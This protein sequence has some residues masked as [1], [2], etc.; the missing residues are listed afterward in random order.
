MLAALG[1]CQAERGGPA[2]EDLVDLIANHCTTV[3]TCRCEGDLVATRCDEDLTDRWNT[4]IRAGEERELQYDA[5]CFDQLTADVDRY[6]CAYSGGESPLCGRFCAVYHG[7]KQ[8]GSSCEGVDSLVSDCAQGLVCSE[9]TCVDPCAVLGGRLLDEPCRDPSGGSVYDDCAAGLFCDRDLFPCQP[10]AELGQPCRSTNGACA[11]GLSCNWDSDVCVTAAAA[12]ESC[13]NV[14]C[15]QGLDCDWINDSR[16]C[17]VEA[18]E[19]EDC[20]QAR[21]AGDLYCNDFNFCQDAPGLDELCL[22]GNICAF[23]L[24]CDVPINRCVALPEADQPCL[25]NR[26]AAGSWCLSSADDP[27]GTCIAPA[28]NGEMCS[29]HS[30]C[31]SG[32]CPNGFCW[33]RSGAGESCAEGELCAPGL[34]CNGQTCEGSLTRAPAVCSYPGW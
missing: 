14:E 17:V 16:I 22:F 21:C 10:L 11:D 3:E 9:G 34:V 15:A 30:Q 29:G 8:L 13:D 24:A 18:L 31:E 5:E 19:G 20:S 1:G 32:Y 12:G 4:R 7:D 2:P 28:L 33:P 25:D 6:G 26:C 27:D 23:G